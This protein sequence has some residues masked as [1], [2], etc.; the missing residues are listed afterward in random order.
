MS[1]RPSLI[2]IIGLYIIPLK[3]KQ[4]YKHDYTQSPKFLSFH[5]GQFKKMGGERQR[6][7]GVFIWHKNNEHFMNKIFEIQEF[8]T[9]VLFTIA[10][11]HLI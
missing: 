2:K 11:Q 6:E 9:S 1:H 4:C 10:P 3:I 5:T 7:E 8:K